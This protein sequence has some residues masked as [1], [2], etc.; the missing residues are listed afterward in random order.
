MAETPPTARSH[1]YSEA[2]PGDARASTSSAAPP[3]VWQYSA[4]SLPRG[5]PSHQFETTAVVGRIHVYSCL[6][7]TVSPAAPARLLAWYDLLF[8][9]ECFCSVIV[10]IVCAC[11]CGVSDA[12][13]DSERS[14]IASWCCF[15]TEMWIVYSVTCSLLTYNRLLL[16]LLTT[17]ATTAGAT[18]VG[19][20]KVRV[21][22]VSVFQHRKDAVTG[23]SL[24]AT[25][26]RGHI[27]AG[28]CCV[29]VL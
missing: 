15:L 1:V 7:I 26:E 6:L 16:L 22:S 14:L 29:V 10:L 11:V 4:L 5:P 21:G 8:V 27:V 28:C 2:G 13:S 25:H 12:S 9:C 18:G 17:T 23:F 24:S 19:A 3:T 20:L